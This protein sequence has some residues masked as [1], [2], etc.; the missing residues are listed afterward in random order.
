[1]HACDGRSPPES[2]QAALQTS[3]KSALDS[4]EQGERARSQ[5]HAWNEVKFAGDLDQN[6]L[7]KTYTVDLMH[8]PG[9]LYRSDM[10]LPD[11]GTGLIPPDEE[12]ARYQRKDIYQFIS[13]T[14]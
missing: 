11:P 14:D 7:Q 8:V 4:A 5:G 10:G 6:G 13:L 3:R 12:V 2:V 1:M 9:A